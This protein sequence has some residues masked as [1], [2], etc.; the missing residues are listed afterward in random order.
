[1]NYDEYV[2][3]GHARCVIYK[4]HGSDLLTRSGHWSRF[5]VGHVCAHAL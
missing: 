5:A 2:R 3:E 4:N 1:M